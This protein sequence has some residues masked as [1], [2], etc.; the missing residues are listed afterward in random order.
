[1]K[2]RKLYDQ[3]IRS[4]VDLKS[5][6]SLLNSGQKIG[7]KHMDDFNKKIPREEVAA[8]FERIREVVEK[9]DPGYVVTACGSFRHE[10][11]F[12][13]DPVMWIRI[14]ESALIRYVIRDSK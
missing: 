13:P 7:L 3:G 14:R 11:F 5:H 12:Y 2:A 1:V 6:Q 4:V 9:L 10:F 8:I